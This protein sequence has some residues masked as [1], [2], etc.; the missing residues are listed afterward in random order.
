MPVPDPTK[1]FYIVQLLFVTGK[2]LVH[3]R[4]KKN[5]QNLN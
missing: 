3:Y 1:I 4:R 2:Q 5:P